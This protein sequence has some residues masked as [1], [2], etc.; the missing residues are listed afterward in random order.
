MYSL[1]QIVT[2]LLLCLDKFEYI[3][4]ESA[5]RKYLE[6]WNK[7][8]LNNMKLHISLMKEGGIVEETRIAIEE[9]SIC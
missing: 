7:S 5:K 1:L 2:L 9:N 3:L 8:T 6:V 4:K